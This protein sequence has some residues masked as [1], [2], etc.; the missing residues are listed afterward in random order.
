MNQNEI[1]AINGRI[2]N[3]V[4]RED[5]ALSPVGNILIN[6][7]THTLKDLYD[8]A[9]LLPSPYGENLK[10]LLLS[11]EDLPKNV[12]KLSSPKEKWMSLYDEVM[13]MKPKFGSNEE[14]LSY[15]LKKY[16]D[17]GGDRFWLE[18]EAESDL[19]EDHREI[20]RVAR[21][22][23]MCRYLIRKERKNAGFFRYWLYRLKS[24]YA[25]CR[26]E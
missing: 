21:S 26:A 12:I 1:F 16:R 4:A 2:K 15:F 3:I 6:T 25:S 14:A 10:A 8:F 13:L 20:M 17:L 19:T 24:L 11:K 5:I 23:Q 22:I 18:A 9:E 7:Y